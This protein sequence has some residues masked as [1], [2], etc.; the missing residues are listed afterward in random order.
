MTGAAKGIGLATLVRLAAEGARVAALDR[1]ARALAAL[2]GR[3][4]QAL[5]HAAAVDVADG[6]A[7]A[8]AVKASATALGGLDGVVNAAGVDLY[9]GI[10]AMAPADWQRVLAVNS[11][12]RFL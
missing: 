1:D 12:A 6:G 2:P 7:V 3:L 11:P 4:D 10:E 8:D 9:A 5:G